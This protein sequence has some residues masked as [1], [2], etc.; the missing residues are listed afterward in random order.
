MFCSGDS[1]LIP[2]IKVLMV[3][4]EFQY[5]LNQADNFVFV[6]LIYSTLT[7]AVLFPMP[8]VVKIERAVCNIG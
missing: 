6:D 8:Q 1:V 3:Q 4:A 2:I 5:A 7:Q